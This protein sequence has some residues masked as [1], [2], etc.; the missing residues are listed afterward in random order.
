MATQRA[1]QTTYASEFKV[2][3]LAALSG[4]YATALL[5]DAIFAGSPNAG[6]TAFIPLITT[7]WQK[8]YGGLY[9]SP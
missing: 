7:S 2:S 6:G 4:P 9:N 3:G 1:M 5:G 8:S